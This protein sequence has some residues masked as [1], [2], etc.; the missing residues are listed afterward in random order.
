MKVSVRNQCIVI[1][2]Y[3]VYDELVAIY[4]SYQEYADLNNCT[5]HCAFQKIHRQLNKTFYIY[6][7][8]DFTNDDFY[9]ADLQS[10]E[11][12]LY[13]VDNENKHL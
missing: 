8:I 6:S 3:N 1:A 10:R 9:M 12:A 11:F 13:E 2:E 5:Y 7:M 4:D